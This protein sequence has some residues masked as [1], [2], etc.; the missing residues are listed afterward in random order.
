MNGKSIQ[1]IIN[2]DDYGFDN[3]KCDVILDAMKNGLI[4]D[5]T[6]IA[7]STS[8][9]YAAGIALENECMQNRVGVHLNL[10]FGKPLTHPI[11]K[12]SKL[13][14]GGGIYKVLNLSS[15]LFNSAQ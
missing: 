7:N 5:T 14:R 15:K 11:T 2:A 1:I 8:F 10:T 3:R 9:D 13:V 12:C 4:T 6:L